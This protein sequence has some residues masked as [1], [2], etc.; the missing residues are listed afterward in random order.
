ML[1]LELKRKL[2]LKVFISVE[3]LFKIDRIVFS[4]VLVLSLPLNLRCICARIHHRCSLGKSIVKP[5]LN[6]VLVV[7]NQMLLGQ[8]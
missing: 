6:D 1:L 4:E 8:S 5:G 7:Q 3:I 2:K